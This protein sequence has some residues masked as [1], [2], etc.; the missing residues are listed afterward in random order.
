MAFPDGNSVL[1]MMPLWC[2]T[3]QPE[4][5]PFDG[6]YTS[7]REVGV[8]P[9]PS[10]V[11]CPSTCLWSL[12]GPVTPVNFEDADLVSRFTFKGRGGTWLDSRYTQH[13]MR[14][15]LSVRGSPR[16]EDETMGQGEAE[17]L[18]LE[19]SAPHDASWS[20]GGI[21]ACS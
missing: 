11:Y 3:V 13:S 16:E 21:Q 14:L 12:P 6:G 1:G 9:P 10:T 18:W 5:L 20:P 7:F 17:C 8:I 4:P 2:H 15:Q 19:Q